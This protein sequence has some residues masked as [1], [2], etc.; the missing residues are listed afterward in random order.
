MNK[1]KECT[2]RDTRENREKNIEYYREYDRNRYRKDGH[3]PREVPY[4]ILNGDKN[5]TR[6]RTSRAIKS[7][8]L[9]KPDTCSMCGVSGVKI[10]AHHRDYS[11]PLDV[12]WVCK[13]CHWK[14]HKILN[15]M[16][17]VVEVVVAGVE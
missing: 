10:E 1:C 6:R 7:G 4:H 12:D 14:I 11:N 8:E 16:E 9:E 5:K 15:E 13:S 2:K 3:R 17:R